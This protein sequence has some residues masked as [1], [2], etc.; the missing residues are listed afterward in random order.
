MFAFIAR[1]C[2]L[3]PR[4]PERKQDPTLPAPAHTDSLPQLEKGQSAPKTFITQG[5][6]RAEASRIRSPETE[7]ERE[8]FF[9]RFI[10]LVY[11]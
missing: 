9:K 1:R 3:E 5:S 10:Y 8:N 6:P 2:L 7:K 4:R 11:S